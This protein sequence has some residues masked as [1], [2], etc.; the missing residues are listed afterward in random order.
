MLASPAANNGSVPI[1][2]MAEGVDYL[3]QQD[4]FRPNPA[5]A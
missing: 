3:D 2:K 4:A 5:R 1:N